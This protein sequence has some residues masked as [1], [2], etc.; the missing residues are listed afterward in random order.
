MELNYIKLGKR[1]RAIRKEKGL[2][3]EKLAEI[4]EL[5]ANHISH[6][7]RANTMVSLPTLVQ[8]VNALGV[9]V[10]DVL[11][12]SVEKA[13]L[14]YINKITSL[15]SDCDEKEIRLFSSVLDT[16]KKTYRDINK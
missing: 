2:T 4:T 8:I 1:I 10:D 6:I 13:K 12:D 9:T 3:Q 15:S 11:C 14:P 16:L 7:E 5:S